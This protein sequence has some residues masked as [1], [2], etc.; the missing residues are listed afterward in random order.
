MRILKYLILATTCLLCIQRASG[1]RLWD[2]ILIDV[3]SDMDAYAKNG[4][5]EMNIADYCLKHLVNDKL[6]DS[7]LFFAGGRTLLPIR[8]FSENKFDYSGIRKIIGDGTS[9]ND[10][11]ASCIELEHRTG[12]FVVISNGRE[13]GSS[14]SYA[15]LSK[16]MNTKGIRVDAIVISSRC[17]SIYVKSSLFN[18]MDSTLYERTPKHFGLKNIVKITGGK[19]I[20][21]T[22]KHD[23]ES[24]IDELSCVV[25]KE[26]IR[27]TKFGCNLNPALTEKVLARL[28]PQKLYICEVDTNVVIKYSGITYHGLNEILNVANFD[29]PILID[30][31]NKRKLE[32]DSPIN[33][34][35]VSKPDEQD[36]KRLILSQVKTDSSYCKLSQDT[37]I[38][39]LPMIY[40]SGR[41]SKMQLCGLEFE[42]A[43]D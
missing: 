31:D 14:F 39:V 11:L 17:D 1:N 22:D 36:K 28:K 29:S 37:P 15:T 41:G 20:T 4:V 5:N 23:L 43:D 42:F 10:A 8:N 24:K 32:G 18:S 27:S 40:Y 26:K 2:I 13:S 12:R 38:D 16:L 21:L 6:A 33:V 7:I 25:A 3:S 34:V 30:R 9:I 19:I 35:F